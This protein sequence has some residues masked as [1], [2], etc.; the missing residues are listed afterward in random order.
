MNDDVFFLAVAALAIAGQMAVSM[1]RPHG[2]APE[3]EA[4]QMQPITVVARR[5]DAEF[6]A[7]RMARVE[8]H[9]H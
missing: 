6:P 8:Q 4:R 9:E 3:P 5:S 2:R 1:Q 7:D